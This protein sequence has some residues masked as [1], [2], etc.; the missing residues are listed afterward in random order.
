MSKRGSWCGETHVQ[1]TTFL[2]QQ[3]LSVDIG[4]EF[5]LY[6]HGPFSFDLRDALSEMVA[7]NLLESVVRQPGYGPSLVPT[8]DS[9]EYLERFPNTLS[10]YAEPIESIA[11]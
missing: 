11:N 3:L 10:S 8:I 1:K 5:V 9:R 2:L 7:D 6:K 4:F